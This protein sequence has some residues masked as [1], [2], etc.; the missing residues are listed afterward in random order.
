MTAT[1]IRRLATRVS[2]SVSVIGLATV[3][4]PAGAQEV[5]YSRA[6]QL[7]NWN[8]DRL[9]SGDQVTPQWLKDG[10]R[11]RRRRRGRC[12]SIR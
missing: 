10:N 3:G 2:A 9:V 1:S 4:A 8:A 7:L 6:E 5:N 11:I 12:C